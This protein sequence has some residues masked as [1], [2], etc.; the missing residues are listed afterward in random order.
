MAAYFNL[1]ALVCKNACFACGLRRC[2]FFLHNT[3]FSS[4]KNIKKNLFFCRK[5]NRSKN[6][7]KSVKNIKNFLNIYFFV[8]K[9]MIFCF[10]RN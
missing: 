2:F 6:I 1:F 8:H 3:L 9:E 5:L 7:F 10:L 4:V